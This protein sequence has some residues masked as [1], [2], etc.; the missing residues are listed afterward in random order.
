M[1]SI[2]ECVRMSHHNC[3]FATLLEFSIPKPWAQEAESHLDVVLSLDI[4]LSENNWAIH[5]FMTAYVEIDFSN[6]VIVKTMKLELILPNSRLPKIREY[7]LR[8]NSSKKSVDECF[9]P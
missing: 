7:S 4:L 9:L 5:V 8:S 2:L 1:G 6:R 3:C